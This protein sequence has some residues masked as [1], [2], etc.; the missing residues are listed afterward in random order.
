V[1]LSKKST[2]LLDNQAGTDDSGT[3]LGGWKQ[4]GVPAGMGLQFG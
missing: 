1:R 4:D 2:E 3:D